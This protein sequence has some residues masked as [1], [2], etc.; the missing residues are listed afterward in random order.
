M[1]KI[2]IIIYKRKP[3]FIKNVTLSSRSKQRFLHSGIVIR[4][5]FDY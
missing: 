1:N 3:G 2:S 5:Y 4:Y